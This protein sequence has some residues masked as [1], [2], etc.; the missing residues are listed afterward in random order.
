MKTFIYTLCDPDTMEVRYVGK[1]N[2]PQKRFYDHIAGVN[3]I[4]H[5]SSWIKSLLKENKKPILNIVDE[6]PIE[7]WQMYEISWINKY[8]KDGCRLTNHSNGGNGT[9]THKYSNREKTIQKLISLHKENPNYNK[10]QDKE[11]IISK[12][13][14]YQKYIVENLSLNKCAV[15]FKTSKCTIFRNITESGIKKDKASWKS[16]LSTKDKKKII[17]Y[18]LSGDI[19]KNWDGASDINRSLGYRISDITACCNGRTNIAHGYIWRYDGDSIFRDK[20]NTTKSKWINQLDF[21]GNIIN[22]FKSVKKASELTKISR[23][24]IGYCCRGINKSAG[25]FI[26]CYK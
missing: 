5:K 8:K 23:T 19:I 10:C 11:H 1:S 17:Q 3:K 12:D 2:N 9:T 18:N 20:N 26:W 24:Q 16:Q 22:E 25:G 4:S 13:D 6:V 21:D 7:N 15:Y 14:L